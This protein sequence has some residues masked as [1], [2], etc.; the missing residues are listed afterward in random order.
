[1]R[2]TESEFDFVD[3][4][5]KRIPRFAIKCGNWLSRKIMG[6]I[7]EERGYQPD[8]EDIHKGYCRYDSDL[9]VCSDNRC[10]S[11]SDCKENGFKIANFYNLDF[12]EALTSAQR[13]EI[14]EF[15][16]G[17]DYLKEEDSECPIECEVE[18]ERRN[19]YFL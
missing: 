1:M 15:W 19:C 13:E 7:L 9:C 11:V 17:K 18:K 14:V 3:F 2:N 4:I 8:K 16:Y 6:E 10:R 5:R 12:G